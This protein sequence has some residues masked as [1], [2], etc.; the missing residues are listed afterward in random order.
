MSRMI[1]FVLMYRR[2]KLLDLI[3]VLFKYF[4]AGVAQ[5]V[6]QQMGLPRFN[7][8]QG[9]EIFLYLTAS[10]RALGP[11]S[12]LSNAYR[13]LFLPVSSGQ[14]VTLTTHFHLVPRSIMVELHPPSP[15]CLHGEINQAQ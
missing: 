4:R 5:S 15:I 10:R 7:S 13:E 14:G 9:H 2:H 3:T 12:L 11:A 6:H 1:I 8:W